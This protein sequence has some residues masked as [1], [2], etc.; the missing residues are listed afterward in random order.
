MKRLNPSPIIYAYTHLKTKQFISFFKDLQEVINFI[1]WHRFILIIGHLTSKY[2]IIMCDIKG[3]L[4]QIW[5]S[6][7]IFV[8]IWNMLKISH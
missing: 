5:K 3:T 7:N 6:N 8:F 2:V 4:M 1:R